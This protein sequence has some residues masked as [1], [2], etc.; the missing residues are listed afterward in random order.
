MLAALFAVLLFGAEPPAPAPR[1]AGTEAPLWSGPELATLFGRIGDAGRARS[2]EEKDSALANVGGFAYRVPRQG[3]ESTDAYSKRMVKKRSPEHPNVKR[4]QWLV[5]LVRQLYD[6][7]GKRSESLARFERDRRQRAY[8]ERMAM[9]A[10][11][12]A[13]QLAKQLETVVEG[14]DGFVAPLPV[15]QGDPPVSYGAQATVKN[16]AITID[17]MDRVHFEGDQVPA[18]TTRT[19]RGA[20]KELFAALKQYNV[21]AQMLGQ[22]ES[23][24]RKNHGHLRAMIPASSPAIYL[25]ELVRA[26]IEAEMRTVHVMTMSPKG[27]LSELAVAVVKPK[28]KG[29]KGEAA[30]EVKCPDAV[31]M[32]KCVEHLAESKSGGGGTLHYRVE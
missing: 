1:A 8:F 22:Y 2:V 26:S 24:W 21:Q 31:T 32:Q 12:A 27:V 30:A 29:K 16:G 3:G 5:A 17:S 10:K 13:D 23:I 18:N 25:N 19:A 9:E 15:A 7:L 14:I 6:D 28:G 11:G 4:D 20:I